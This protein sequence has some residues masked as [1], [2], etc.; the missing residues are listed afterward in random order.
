[1]E[2]R[3]SAISKE[4]IS[5]LPGF[6]M[7]AGIMSFLPA[8]IHNQ[9]VTGPI[10]N[11]VLYI[12][13][14]FFSLKDCFLLAL[15]PSI[16]AAISNLLPSAMIPMLPYIIVSNFILILI[17]QKI[18][19]KNYW[20][21]VFLASSAKFLFLFLISSFFAGL[22]FKNTLP[23]KVSQMMAWPQLATA[24]GGGIIAYFILTKINKK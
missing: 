14:Y 16:F 8:M 2:T 24:L 4:K 21:G 19:D 7:L 13:T 17:F 15:L 18:K 22:F 9:F 1:M 3:I 23:L 10:V 11:A 20:I 5:S 12:S 6:L